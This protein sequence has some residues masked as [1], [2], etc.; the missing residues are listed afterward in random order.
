MPG[1]SERRVPT[2]IAA[3]YRTYAICTS[4][5]K[6]SFEATLSRLGVNPMNEDN[7]KIF[8]QLGKI[9]RY[10]DICINLA[11]FSRAYPSFAGNISL[12]ALRPYGPNQAAVCTPGHPLCYVHA[13][14]Q[15]IFHYM[16]HKAGSDFVP[17]VLG[18]SKAACYLCNLFISFHNEY[19]VSKTHGQ[20]Y[21]QWTVPDLANVRPQ[22]QAS[23]RQVIQGMNTAI[24][25]DTLRNR[26]QAKKRQN[27]MDSWTSFHGKCPAPPAS[28]TSTVLSQRIKRSP[29]ND[30]LMFRNRQSVLESHDPDM[31]NGGSDMANQLILDLVSDKAKHVRRAKDL[32]IPKDT[33]KEE[34]V[35]SP[36]ARS[37]TV[38][39]AQSSL[40]RVIRSSDQLFQHSAPSIFPNESIQLTDSA[41]DQSSTATLQPVTRHGEARSSHESVDLVSNSSINLNGIFSPIQRRITASSPL[42]LHTP[43][44]NLEI[45]CEDNT[46]GEITMLPDYQSEK[47][48]SLRHVDVALLDVEKDLILERGED[49]AALDLELYSKGQATL[50]M[51][52]LKWL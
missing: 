15:L 46:I 18:T 51:V 44:F 23:I 12:E 52:S 36:G 32:H 16:L 45:Q 39:R 24:M 14:I 37:L 30:P 47:E 20:L 29:A 2:L 42:C 9:C 27:P 35:E 19:F 22:D 34:I 5:G 38:E 21:N 8:N 4:D 25:K 1:D 17:R 10:W 40:S 6:F 48:V 43:S 3:V 28:D 41:S 50:S 13:E 33:E 26:G 31:I 7:R 11:T 49:S